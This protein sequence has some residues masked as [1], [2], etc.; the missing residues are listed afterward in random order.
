LRD[1]GDFDDAVEVLRDTVRT[2]GING[3]DL[4]RA[5]PDLHRAEAVRA[6]ELVLA[7]A[8]E[9]DAKDPRIYNASAMLALRQGKA[10]E[11]FDRFDQAVVARRQLHRRA[12]QQGRRAARCGRLHA[13]Q[14]RADDDVEK[15]PDDFA[16]RSRSGIA[17]RGLKEF[18]EAK[19]TWESV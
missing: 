17:H 11:A 12:V 18:P 5:R 2:S 1:A 4:H 13:S 7:K 19:K 3:E 15:R 16:R 10:Q 14:D 9:L 8:V 6:R